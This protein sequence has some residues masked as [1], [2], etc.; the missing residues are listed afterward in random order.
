[1]TKPT[2]PTKTES[3]KITLARPY[4]RQG[5]TLSELTM[6]R[7][8]LKDH[9]VASKA[10]DVELEGEAALFASLC[11][12]TPEDLSEMD[13]ADYKRLQAVYRDFLK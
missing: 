12:V 1:M 3:A 9:I 6:R 2:E 13:M 8:K 7:P 10:S 11:G 5:N 4:T